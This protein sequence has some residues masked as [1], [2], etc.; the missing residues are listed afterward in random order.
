MDD[1]VFSLLEKM[2]SELTTKIDNVSVELQEVKGEAKKIQIK[3][4]NDIKPKIDMCLEELATVL[5]CFFPLS[6]L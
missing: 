4:E 1:K 6:S 5:G 2:Y 3:L